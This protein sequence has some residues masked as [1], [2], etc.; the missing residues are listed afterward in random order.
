[1]THICV[2]NLTIIGSDNGLSPDR[3]Q[4]IN[5]TN[6]EIL[7]IG[8]LGTNFSENLIGIQTFSFYKMHLK[9]SSAEWHPFCLCLNVLRK[10]NQ[11]QMMGIA[12][13]YRKTFQ[14]LGGCWCFGS[15]NYKNYLPISWETLYIHMIQR[16]VPG[17]HFARVS[18][19]WLWE[20]RDPQMREWIWN[21]GSHREHTSALYI[22]VMLQ[23]R[24]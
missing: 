22:T 24:G 2:S 11:H 13:D 19:V 5:C 7:L 20:M 9:M 6:A 15:L 23:A 4:A 12:F 21:G 8:P 3:R 14:L 1:M 10:V 18:S 16:P 17:N